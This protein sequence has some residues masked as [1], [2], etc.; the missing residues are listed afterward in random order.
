MAVGSDG[1]T[2]IGRQDLVDEVHAVVP[3][4][5]RSEVN[6]VINSLIDSI[7]SHL[8]DDE[9]VSIKGFGRFEVKRRAP[10][11]ARNVYS[12]EQVDV[13]ATTRI[14]FRP[15]KGGVRV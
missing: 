13:P 3:G 10:R 15:S 11:K 5:L 6:A 2:I 4:I 9:V 8:E 7:L 1:R 12:G 14:V